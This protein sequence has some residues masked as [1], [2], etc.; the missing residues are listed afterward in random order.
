M[1]TQPIRIETVAD[2]IWQFAAR[3]NGISV[4]IY[5]LKGDL[6]AVVDTGYRFHPETT[7]RPALAQLGILPTD[8]DLILNTHGHPDHL[9]GNAALK[10]MSGAD[11]AVPAGD[12]HLANGVDVHLH[13]PTDHLMAMQALG[14]TDQIREREAFLRDRVDACDVDRVL[15]AGD[16]VDLGGDLRFT[17]VPTPGHSVG[18]V[19]FYC[20]PLGVALTGDAVQGWG[21]SPQNLPLYYDPTNYK[22]SLSRICSLHPRVIAMGHGTR[23]SVKSDQERSVRTGADIQRTIDESILFADR[24]A[25]AADDAN[26]VDELAEQIT[27]VAHNLPPEHDI[28]TD[29]QGRMS[30]TSAATI[31]S[32][33][34][35]TGSGDRPYEPGSAED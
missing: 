6:I 18:S 23:G 32:Q 8:V 14:W 17:V 5:V 12:A 30:A 21:L 13:S 10:A 7:I 3:L 16:T 15:A 34:R 19:T 25:A 4:S 29:A 28:P 1:T 24:L 35:H 27:M 11:I 33:L 26:Q 22:A 20:E 2:G 31:I 9:G